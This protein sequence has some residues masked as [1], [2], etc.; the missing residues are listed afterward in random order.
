MEI[1]ITVSKITRIPSLCN[2]VS[3]ITAYEAMQF[4]AVN[5]SELF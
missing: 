5:F 3:S 1:I 2:K 4:V